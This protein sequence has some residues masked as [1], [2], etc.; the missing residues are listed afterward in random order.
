[1]S[2]S[3]CVSATDGRTDGRID[4]LIARARPDARLEKRTNSLPRT[5]GREP[6]THTH[7]PHTHTARPPIDRSPTVHRSFLPR[8]AQVKESTSA[9]Q[10]DIESRDHHER[11][12]RP[13]IDFSRGRPG[14]READQLAR[15]SPVVL[16]QVVVVVPS[17]LQAVRFGPPKVPPEIHPGP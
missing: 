9:E 14:P 4:W 7:T 6:R 13:P 5:E 15:I 3:V 16:L 1:M 12:C 2:A 11:D 8:S 17:L 10:D